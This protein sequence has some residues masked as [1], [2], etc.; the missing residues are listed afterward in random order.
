MGARHADRLWMIG[1]VVAAALLIVSS[2]FL[3]INPKNAE[4]DQLHEEKET[5]EIRLITL[6]QGLTKLQQDNEK[7]P[8]Y[9]ATLARNR[10]ALPEDSGVPEF[11]RQLQDTENSFGVA[12]TSIT[13]SNPTLVTGTAV[14]TVPITLTAEGN[15]D[16]LGKYLDQLQ[17]TQPR[18]VLIDS[19]NFA[20]ASGEDADKNAPTLTISLKAYVAP[21]AGQPAPT[22]SPTS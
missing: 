18:A 11:L 8:Q 20:A 14:Y 2:W 13:V 6:R 3:A 9:K 16:S 1:G 5:T 7:L 17:R 22:I 15:A 10:L 12:V 4:A 21:K 19:T